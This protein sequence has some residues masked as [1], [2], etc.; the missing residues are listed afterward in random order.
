MRH[1]IQIH[2]IRSLIDTWASQ[3]RHVLGCAQ[4]VLR[5]HTLRI[6]SATHGHWNTH[7]PNVNQTCMVL[8]ALHLNSRAWDKKIWINYVATQKSNVYICPH[9]DLHRTL[10][11]LVPTCY[12]GPCSFLSPSQPVWPKY[13][14]S[15]IRSFHSFSSK[16]IEDIQL[17]SFA[18]LLFQD[19]IPV[20][21]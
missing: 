2:L 10:E 7:W 12:S 15:T 8:L 16:P 21:T 20:T 19:L 11:W 1:N 3:C 17:L 9:F 14:G 6:Q 5:V 13:W 4:D 18:V